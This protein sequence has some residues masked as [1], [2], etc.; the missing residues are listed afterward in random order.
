MFEFPFEQSARRLAFIITFFLSGYVCQAQEATPSDASILQTI[1]LRQELDAMKI[2]MRDT[3]M[4]VK[5]NA[6][7]LIYYW[8]SL[9]ET[10]IKKLDSMIK[11]EKT[12]REE[13]PKPVPVDTSIVSKV[14]EL[15][16]EKREEEKALAKSKKG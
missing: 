11:A 9:Q 7:S 16:E 13:L 2:I 12:A 15:L 14:Y 8:N 1:Q 6:M 5:G 10:K 3:I 4:N